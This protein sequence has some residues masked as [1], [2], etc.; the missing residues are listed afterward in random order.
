[1][2][3]YV[4]VQTLA[5]AQVLGQ[6]AD[7]FFVPVSLYQSKTEERLGLRPSQRFDVSH[8]FMNPIINGHSVLIPSN[9]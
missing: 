1:M 9:I 6:R 2:C 7:S 8:I 3:V 5:S 4:C